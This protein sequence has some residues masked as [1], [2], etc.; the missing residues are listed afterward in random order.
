MGWIAWW[1]WGQVMELC[2]SH[3][4]VSTLSRII[5][6]LS[7]RQKKM[8]SLPSPPTNGLHLC[9]PVVRL[10]IAWWSWGQ[11]MELCASH[12]RASTLSRIILGLS[13]P[14]KKMSSLPLPPTNG[15]HL[16][17]LVV[18]SWIAWSRAQPRS[19][20]QQRPQPRSR[21]Q[22]HPPRWPSA[23]SHTW[24]LALAHTRMAYEPTIVRLQAELA[25]AQRVNARTNCITALRKLAPSGAWTLT[26]VLPSTCYLE[27]ALRAA[28]SIRRIS[29][30]GATRQLMAI[31]LTSVM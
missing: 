2:A 1:S 3:R 13:G 7:G 21:P 23:S 18:R 14:Q 15:L 22:L 19:P 31:V 25:S 26:N 17:P 27:A 12:R 24:L 29:S 20:P 30:L 28:Q 4:R 9:R 6:G 11:V 16:C 5:W 10:W 8:S